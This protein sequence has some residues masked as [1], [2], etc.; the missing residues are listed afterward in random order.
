MHGLRIGAEFFSYVS[1]R[2]GDQLDLL[3]Y[4]DQLTPDNHRDIFGICC[5]LID[6]EVGEFDAMTRIRTLNLLP[7]SAAQGNQRPIT[8]LV[9]EIDSLKA[10]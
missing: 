7:L 2:V 5:I 10:P 8:N 6:T 1:R 9:Q 4:S 3:V